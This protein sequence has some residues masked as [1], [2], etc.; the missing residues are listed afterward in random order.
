MNCKQV[1]LALI[2]FTLP[3][4]RRYDMVTPQKG[5]NVCGMQLVQTSTAL[6]LGAFH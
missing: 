6:V 5:L 3:Q 1:S 4:Q 2:H